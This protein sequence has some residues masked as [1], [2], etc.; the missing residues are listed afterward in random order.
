MTD[1]N[2]DD[3]EVKMLDETLPENTGL[4]GSKRKTFSNHHRHQPTMSKDAEKRDRSAPMIEE[5][6]QSNMD[7]K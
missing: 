1:E 7:L 5:L 2:D 3:G 6:L 4:E